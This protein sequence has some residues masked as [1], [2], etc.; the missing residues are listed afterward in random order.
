M[1]P[2]VRGRSR[3]RGRG[4]ER[5]SRGAPAAARG[6]ARSLLGPAAASGALGGRGAPS[7]GP[8]GARALVAAVRRRVV[9]EAGARGAARRPPDRREGLEPLRPLL[10]P[11][12]RVRLAL[13]L[14]R[15]RRGVQGRRGGRPR[16]GRAA[17]CWRCSRSR[18]RRRPPTTTTP[19]RELALALFS[20]VAVEGHPS[21]EAQRRAAARAGMAR[22]R[23][24]P[25]ADRARGPRRRLSRVDG[26]HADH[27]GAARHDGGAAPH[28][29]RRRPRQPLVGL[30]QHGHDV[31]LQGAARRKRGARR[32]RRVPATSTRA[33]T[34][35]SATPS[36]VSR[37]LSRRGC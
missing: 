12:A 20:L 19:S 7:R 30:P 25:R 21:V 16:E 11:R 15:L 37:I 28:R 4:A 18:T 32:R 34:S 9:R 14:R 29:D 6:G 10:E 36:T 24:H 5:R 2:G 35:C 23:Q 13:R 31:P 22:A 27:L 3:H 8:A 1:G 33:T 17:R 26:L